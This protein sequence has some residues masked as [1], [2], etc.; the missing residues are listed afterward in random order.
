M[1]VDEGLDLRLDAMGAH[2]GG[3]PVD[4]GSA[5]DAGSVYTFMPDG[6]G[7]NWMEHQKLTPA[8]A[9]GDIRFGVKVDIDAGQQV[10]C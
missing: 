3:E 1:P 7:T 9:T 10:A 5:G 2:L 8:D 6:T 4:E